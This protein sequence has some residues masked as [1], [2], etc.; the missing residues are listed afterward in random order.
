MRG[1]KNKLI[2]SCLRHKY[3]SIYYY[4]Y[5]IDSGWVETSNYN[6]WNLCWSS[7]GLL[8]SDF[9]HLQPFQKINMFPKTVGLTRKDLLWNNV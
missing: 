1:G 4:Y 9:Q 5:Y 8:P 7:E 2:Q 6:D 3:L